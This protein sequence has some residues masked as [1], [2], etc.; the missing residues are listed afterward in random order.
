MSASPIKAVICLIGAAA[1]L[2]VGGRGTVGEL[3]DQ[4]I[5]RLFA[6][7]SS[8]KDAAPVGIGFL[9]GPGRVLTCAH[10]VGAATGG[11]PVRLGDEVTI[12]FPLV[13]PGE[14]RVATVVH[15]ADDEVDIAGLSVESVP[16]GSKA[17]RVVTADDVTGHQ[18]RAFG[19]TEN[20]DRGV[21]SEGVVRGPIADGVLQIEDDRDYGVPMQR[22]FSGSPLVDLDSRAVIGMIIDVENRPERRIAYALSGDALHDSWQQLGD[23]AA[24]PSP[25]RSLQPFRQM[26]ADYFFGRDERIRGVADK[27]DRDGFRLI[28]GPSGCGKSSLVL[29]GILP[30]LISAGAGAVVFRPAAG[31]SP[32]RALAGALLDQLHPDERTLTKMEELAD[33]LQKGSLDDALNRILITR[34][35]RRLVIVVDQFDEALAQYPNDSEMLLTAL[36]DA[37]RSHRREPRVD[38]L[39]TISSES[40]DGILSSPRV[41]HRI[42]GNIEVLTAPSGPELRTMIEGP[43]AAPGMPVYERGLVDTLLRDVGEER[44]PLPLIEFTLTLLWERQERGR[45]T[46][47]VYRELGGVVGALALYAEQICQRYLVDDARAARL[48]WLLCQMVSPVDPDRFVRRMVSLEQLETAAELARELAESR[49]VTLGTL[50]DDRVTAE[51]AHEALVR[52]WPRLHEWVAEDRDFRSWQDELDRQVQR[53]HLQPGNARLLRGAALRDARIQGRAHRDEMTQHQ[54]AFIRASVT[55]NTIRWA[56]RYL[57]VV[58]VAALGASIF[59]VVVKYRGQQSD[60]NAIDAAQALRA[61]S[62]QLGDTRPLQSLSLAIRGFRTHDDLTTRSQLY[63]WADRLRFADAILP[64]SYR[65]L[66]AEPINSDAS[67]VVLQ[68]SDGRLEAWDLTRSRPVKVDIPAPHGAHTSIAW[69]GN[70]QL[71]TSYANGPS[72]VWDAHSGRPVRKLPFGGD[73]LITD[74]T[75]RWVGYGNSGD[76]ALRLVD[77]ARAGAARREIQF[78]SELNSSGQLPPGAIVASKVLSSGAVLAWRDAKPMLVDRRGVKSFDV[79]NGIELLNADAKEPRM[80]SCKRSD[81]SPVMRLSGLISGHVYGSYRARGVVDCNHV[82]ATFSTDGEYA[83]AT[84]SA[85][86]LV[87]TA[88]GKSGERFLSFSTPDGF[89]PVRITPEPSGSQRILFAGE[90]SML[91]V[92][93]ARPDPLQ[94]ALSDASRAELVGTCL[95]LLFADRHIEAWDVKTRRRTGTGTS[96][97]GSKAVEELHLKVDPNGRLLALVSGDSTPIQLWRLPGLLPLGRIDMEA[98]TT[99]DFAGSR[100]L[101]AHWDET[102]AKV[103]IWD[104]RDFRRLTGP[105]TVPAKHESES[106]GFIIFRPRSNELIAHDGDQVRR[107]RISDGATVPGSEFSVGGHLASWDIPPAVDDS[108]HFLALLQSNYVDIWNLGS[109]RRVGR[110]YT[111]Q[112][113]QVTNV[114]FREDPNKLELAVADESTGH[115]VQM[116]LW[117]RN[118]LLGVPGW[119]GINDSKVDVVPDSLPARLD[120]GTEDEG[121]VIDS[122]DPWQWLREICRTWYPNSLDR[123]LANAPASAWRGRV[124]PVG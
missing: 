110:L 102:D 86:Q 82:S 79:P 80:I 101:V 12:D 58:L 85:L 45:L 119:F 87:S 19:V 112:G 40:L 73:I 15:L 88:A 109:H 27:L 65:Y 116:K 35:L 41:G 8:A 115:P 54:H 32:W 121:Y 18:V 111:P 21:W 61:R 83:A 77:T 28:S 69:L 5:V 107:V 113:T 46:H 14:E 89:S 1:I 7:S 16:D 117:D 97:V 92:R 13:A 76:R 103:S 30:V 70:S 62:D 108:G 100:L 124:C 39:V 99:V 57:A 120:G 67:G 31:S 47:A 29:A 2:L 75:G 53:W 63:R 42:A 123:D 90:D 84:S 33:Q 56:Y 25:F 96:V 59:A 66:A 34:D 78:P 37:Q 38:V 9:V 93:V 64:G 68:A 22:G 106:Q 52:H 6:K 11:A 94:S 60:Q 50:T 74:A 122:T 3:V 72:T 20:R 104:T 4:A 105:I 48:R 98:P 26:D 10:V 118:R 43:L 81:G 17:L 49:L 114:R 51:L 95:I 36:L 24:Q 55:F 23:I 71:I 44:N 91:L